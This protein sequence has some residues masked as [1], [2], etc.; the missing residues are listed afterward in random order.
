MHLKLPIVSQ[1]TTKQSVLLVPSNVQAFDAAESAE[2]ALF[3]DSIM[4]S[5]LSMPWILPVPVA[6]I[7][8]I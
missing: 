3:A 2:A 1:A 6:R 7:C 5:E 8:A 4:A